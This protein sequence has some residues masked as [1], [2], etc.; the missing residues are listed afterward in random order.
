MQGEY[1]SVTPLGCMGGGGGGT[2]GKRKRRGAGGWSGGAGGPGGSGRGR[3]GGA[4]PRPPQPPAPASLSCRIGVRPSSGRAPL[5][6]GFTARVTNALG[7]LSHAWDF[8]DGT[9]S[10]A[11]TP[12]HT[13]REPATYGATLRVEDESGRTCTCSKT[14]AVRRR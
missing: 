14:I 1:Q 10:S 13:F 2:A 12:T 3:A 6:V 9:T 5:R 7:R 4:G 11:A 8:D